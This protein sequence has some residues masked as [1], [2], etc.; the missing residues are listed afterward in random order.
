MTTLIRLP[1]HEL[2]WRFALRIEHVD[3]EKFQ[4]F[5]AALKSNI[6]Q[7]SRKW[8][9]NRKCWLLR[10]ADPVIALLRS[11]AI[12]FDC[13]DAA[14]EPE[15][16]K[17]LT[18]DDAYRIL[19]LQPDA[20]RFIVDAAYRALA[21]HFHPDVGGDTAAMQRINAAVEVLR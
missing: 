3:S 15:R 19:Y 2:P 6:H 16:P 12:D 20:P 4:S 1:G 18:V 8:D 5:I 10:D 11:F 13:D 9:A 7:R 21:K 14:A 17:R